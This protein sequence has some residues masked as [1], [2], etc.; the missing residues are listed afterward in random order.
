MSECDF[1]PNP[2]MQGF[3]VRL[4]AV[5]L[6]IV[7]E[8]PDKHIRMCFY[9]LFFQLFPIII[10][11]LISFIRRK[12]SPGDAWFALLVMLSPTTLEMLDLLPFHRRRAGKWSLRE[13]ADGISI[14]LLLVLS[15]A[16]YII[17]VVF[18]SRQDS[19]CQLEGFYSL[20]MG[21]SRTGYYTS[22]AVA[23]FTV[24][25]TIFRIP[26]YQTMKFLLQVLLW[27]PSAG[28]DGFRI[29][30]VVF[31][32]L[33][34]VQ[35]LGATQPGCVVARWRSQNADSPHA[36]S[37]LLPIIRRGVMGGFLVITIVVFV[38]PTQWVVRVAIGFCLHICILDTRYEVSDDFISIVASLSFLPIAAECLKLAF[39]KHR[40]PSLRSLRLVLLPLP[41]DQYGELSEDDVFP[42]EFWK[43]KTRTA[44]VASI[45]GL[46]WAGCAVAD[47][48]PK[49]TA[50]RTVVY[51]A[52][53]SIRFPEALKDAARSKP[54]SEDA[55]SRLNLHQKPIEMKTMPPSSLP[56]SPQ[57]FVADKVDEASQRTPLSSDSAT[58][59][60]GETIV[61]EPDNLSYTEESVVVMTGRQPNSTL[62]DSGFIY[63]LVISAGE[64]LESSPSH[65][66]SGENIEWSVDLPILH[67]NVSLLMDIIQTFASRA[68]APTN[69]KVN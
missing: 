65:E 52:F 48:L 14:I 16:L 66:R 42:K 61:D 21:D 57:I 44:V 28:Y 11:T 56:V 4:A 62:I 55:N 43:N 9:A 58:F 19:G 15:I 68:P 34:A 39:Q 25:L 3:A 8:D 37:R 20:A 12:L 17:I 31:S 50:M 64:A 1:N 5:L 54:E 6:G 27:A 26:G 35:T 32:I 2:D 33:S 7:P 22:F 53:P 10:G 69:V 18:L 24:F 29:T 46:S 40:W 59:L 23:L 13:I 49:D 63:Q 38:D 41:L 36:K 51:S 30:S 60:S 47:R 67:R 45:L